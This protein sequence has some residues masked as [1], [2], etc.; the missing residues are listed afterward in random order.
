VFEACYLQKE[1]MAKDH[2]RLAEE[3]ADTES[4]ATYQEMFRSLKERGLRGV[5][6]V[7]SEDHEGLKAALVRLFQGASWQRCQVHYV[8]NRLATNTLQV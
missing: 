1:R 7:I 5:E 2:R 3:V 8:G 6:L 4:E